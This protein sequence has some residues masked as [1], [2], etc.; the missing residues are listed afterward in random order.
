MKVLL[1]FLAVI[2]VL[3]VAKVIWVSIATRH[4]GDF[5]SEKK[6]LLSRRDFLLKKVITSPHKLIEEMPRMVG[7]QFQGEWA[8]YS[9]SMLSAALVNEMIRPAIWSY[10]KYL[11]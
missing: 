8:L 9:C 3:V 6:D 11:F 10:K 5:E 2:F 1:L 7:P 4:D